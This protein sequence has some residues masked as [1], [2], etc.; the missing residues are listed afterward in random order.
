M[1]NTI[2]GRFGAAVLALAVGTTAFAADAA[3]EPAERYI[4]DAAP[5]LQVEPEYPPALLKAGTWALVSLH[6]SRRPAL[7]PTREP[8]S[9]LRPMGK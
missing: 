2:A 9:R 5:T 1:R 3:R 8:E 6:S 7:D 4:V